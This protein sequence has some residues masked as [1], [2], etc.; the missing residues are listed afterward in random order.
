MAAVA[1]SVVLAVF[2][3][4]GAL[5]LDSRR[6]LTCAVCSAAGGGTAVLTSVTGWVG[7]AVV[8]AGPG[9]G[10]GFRRASR[11]RPTRAT[12][13]AD[14]RRPP[15]GTRSG[16]VVTVRRVVVVTFGTRSVTPGR[17]LLGGAAAATF[18]AVFAAAF[19]RLFIVSL[20]G[21]LA[22]V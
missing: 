4:V 5:P 15:R 3:D 17:T 6:R 20:F 1:S 21:G 9:V 12:P 18:A 16:V 13:T 14:S 10:E 22:W 2:G 11:R 19:R 8:V 7:T